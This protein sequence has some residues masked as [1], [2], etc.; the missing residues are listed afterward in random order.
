[1]SFPS[2]VREKVGIRVHHEVLVIQPR[3]LSH[4]WIGSEEKAPM[5]PQSYQRPEQA[6]Q[7]HR[8]WKVTIPMAQGRL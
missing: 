5:H 7:A 3:N 4:F 1:M 6:Y 2:T 8:L